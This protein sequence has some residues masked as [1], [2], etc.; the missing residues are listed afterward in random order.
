MITIT[1]I[2][3]RMQ[4]LKNKISEET[5]DIF[6]QHYD[7]YSNTEMMDVNLHGIDTRTN[8]TEGHTA[9]D[10]IR[11]ITNTH[12]P[13]DAYLYANYQ[14]QTNPTFM[15]VD[16]WGR[17]RKQPTHTIIIPMHQDKR[18]G[19][20]IFKEMFNSNA[21]F[22]D[23]L[24][25]F[26]YDEKQKLTN[27]SERYKLGHTPTNYKNGDFLVDFLEL[28]GVFEYNLGDYVL[29]DTNKLHVSTDFRPFSEYKFKDLVQIHIGKQNP[30]NNSE[31]PFVSL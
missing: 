30:E 10:E 21:D 25:N 28:E 17:D 31:N 16:E 1:R 12:F 29:F 8:I 19:V 24:M 26:P 7:K 22:K 15:H 27:V 18:L 11:K 2:S 4:V 9:F 5:L 6:R 23:F 13:S 3:I 20:A 14:R